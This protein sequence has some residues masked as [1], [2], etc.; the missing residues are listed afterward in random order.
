M[1]KEKSSFPT[2]DFIFSFNSNILMMQVGKDRFGKL[3]KFQGL[4]S[5][6]FTPPLLPY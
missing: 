2:E 6:Q 5:H 3:V 4:A 1:H